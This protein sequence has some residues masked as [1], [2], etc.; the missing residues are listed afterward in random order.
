[1]SQ[2]VIVD[3][4]DANSRL[5]VVELSDGRRRVIV[6]ELAGDCWYDRATMAAPIST[7]AAQRLVDEHARFVAGPVQARF[8]AEATA[9]RRME[10]K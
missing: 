10:V 5:M 7:R 2:N 9:R 6:C 8:L 3:A 4:C 1:M